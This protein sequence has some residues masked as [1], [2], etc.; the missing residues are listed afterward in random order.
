MRST[1]ALLALA[2]GAF[3]RPQGVTTEIAPSATAPAGCSP[4]YPGTFE[5][6]VVNA[7]TSKKRD[8]VR[9]QKSGILKLSLAGG[10]LHDQA[11]RTG[12]VAANYQIQFDEPPQ[13]GA[14]YTSGF[15]VC[16]NGSLALGGSAVF[17]QCDSGSFF[18]LYDRSWAAQCTPIYIVAEGGAPAASQASDGQPAGKTAITAP[19]TQL[20]DG[21][22][23]ASTLL[24]SPP[25]V[26]QLSDGQPG[27]SSALPAPVSQLSDGQPQIVSA[28]PVSVLTDGQIQA[29]TGVP[30]SQATDGQI[31][32]PTGAPVSQ[33]SD[34]Q[35]QAPTGTPVS[36]I[37]DGQSMYTC[38]IPQRIRRIRA[39]SRMVLQIQS[40][41]KGYPCPWIF[42]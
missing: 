8:L 30:V 38:E 36:E 21:Q 32:G 22:P 2:A 25:V 13:T 19:V 18:N 1:F 27:I 6:T 17:Y 16:G 29:P 23:G 24:P 20:T 26:T 37:T 34:G 11:G 41:V 42:A 5:I 31:Q 9:R 7:T 40:R 14:I 33:I 12:Y 28:A 4:T 3:A 35:P 39:P 15:S 10:V